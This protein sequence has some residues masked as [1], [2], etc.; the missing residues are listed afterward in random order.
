MRVYVG[1]VEADAVHNTIT[2]VW[3]LE[4]KTLEI[5]KMQEP[6]TSVGLND[7]IFKNAPQNIEKTTISIE[8]FYKNIGTYDWY[9][10]DFFDGKDGY[11][12]GFIRNLENNYT[13]LN[14]IKIKRMII[15]IR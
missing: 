4:N 9:E 5:L 13:D 2:S 12:Y 6:L 10:S 11:Y 8:D 14:R 15:A 3:P 7:P 1:M